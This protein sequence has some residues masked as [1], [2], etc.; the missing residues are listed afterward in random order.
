MTSSL[1]PSSSLLGLVRIGDEAASSTSDEPGDL[2]QRRARPARRCSFPPPRPCGRRRG[3][4]SITRRASVDQLGGQDG[5]DH[6]SRQRGRVAGQIGVA[7]CPAS[8]R[9]PHAQR[10]QLRGVRAAAAAR[11]APTTRSIV[12][13]I[14][15]RRS[16]GRPCLPISASTIG[17]SDGRAGS[18]IEHLLSSAGVA[19]SLTNAGLGAA[20]RPRRLARGI[21]RGERR[22][23]AA[24]VRRRPAAT[25]RSAARVPV[26]ACWAARRSTSAA[27]S[28]CGEARRLGCLRRRRRG[29][30]QARQRWRRIV[31]HRDAPSAPDQVATACAA[32]PSPRPVKP[33][34]SVVVA[35][36]L[37]ALDVNAEQ[38]RRAARAS[39]RGAGRSWAPR[40]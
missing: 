4:A 35:L 27:T 30:E 11:A 29:G 7:P 8:S 19:L 5:V 34:R 14:A 15:R 33:S 17:C 23:R 12:R 40:R 6:R 31:S 36:T 2:G 38:C 26:I 39:P 9:V 13:A 3:S 16:A 20:A 10:D 37:T 18:R 32:M 28:R 24:Q 25:A 21:A 22:R 1:T